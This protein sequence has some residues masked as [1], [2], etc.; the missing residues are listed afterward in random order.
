[1]TITKYQQ[2]FKKQTNS[3]V[4]SSFALLNL[5]KWFQSSDQP[6][7]ATSLQRKHMI[8]NDL[9][10]TKTKVNVSSIFSIKRITTK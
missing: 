6:Q 10:E 5:S 8:V 2:T 9:K 4:T 1:M 7:Y 3:I